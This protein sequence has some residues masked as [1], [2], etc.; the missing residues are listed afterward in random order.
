MKF[1]T[2]DFIQKAKEKHGD[3][4][5][6]SKVIYKR[7]CE[8]ISIKCPI[9]GLYEQIANDHLKGSG[10]PSCGAKS[11]WDVRGR[12]TTKSFVEKSKTIHGDKYDYSKS[13]YRGS[14]QKLIITCREHGDFEVSP[15]NHL[16]GCGCNKCKAKKNG[17]FR[18]KSPELFVKEAKRIH[19]DKYDYSLVNYTGLNAKIQIICL[20]HGMFEQSA[21]S[22]ILGNGCPKCANEKLSLQFRSD[23]ECFIEKAKVVHGNFYDYKNVKYINSKTNVDIICPKHGIFSQTPN[24]HLSGSGCPKCSRSKGEIKIAM[25]LEKNN[26]AYEEQFVIRNEN[27]FCKNRIIKVDFYIPDKNMFIE[28]NGFQHYQ[29]SDFFDK[30]RTFEEQEDR[31]FALKQYC[32]SHNIILLEIPYT[33]LNSINKILDKQLKGKQKN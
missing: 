13:V 14:K 21:G 15:N 17:D 24:R 22:H 16:C 2:E 10:C 23:K 30:R 4:Y 6:Y 32:K 28:F 1:T 9:H 26:I 3:K 33:K 7:S 18:R 12:M 20:L 19:N 31:D 5:D 11:A 25:Y 29:K 27:L 8:K